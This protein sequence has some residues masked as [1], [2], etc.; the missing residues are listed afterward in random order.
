MVSQ[1][2]I[3]TRMGKPTSSTLMHALMSG[4]RMHVPER[5]MLVWMFFAKYSRHALLRRI[6]PRGKSW[7]PDL[8]L[9]ASRRDET[10][11]SATKCRGNGTRSARAWWTRSLKNR[12]LRKQIFTWTKCG[13][14][15]VFKRISRKRE[16]EKKMDVSW[17]LEGFDFRNKRTYRP[18]WNRNISPCHDLGYI[19]S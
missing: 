1:W 10:T 3:S 18:P 7:N 6:L 9:D 5:W 19:P 14:T 15:P 4:S 12:K 17:G 13:R 2:N 8:P 16:T 11:K